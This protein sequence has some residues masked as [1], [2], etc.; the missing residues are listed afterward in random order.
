M[1]FIC[2]FHVIGAVLLAFMR[3]KPVYDQ[4]KKVYGLVT[5]LILTVWVENGLSTVSIGNLTFSLNKL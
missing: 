2:S 5:V 1:Y 3:C 4:K